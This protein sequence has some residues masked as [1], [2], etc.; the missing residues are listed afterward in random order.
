MTIIENYTKVQLSMTMGTRDGKYFDKGNVYPY[1]SV[2]VDLREGVIL[3]FI[4]NNEIIGDY[5]F[6]TPPNRIYV[7]QVIA[8]DQVMSSAYF[9]WIDMPQITI[10][11]LTGRCLGFN[12]HIVVPARTSI[13]YTGREQDGIQLGFVL[14]NDDGIYQD[15]KITKKITDVY[16]G[17][18]S[19]EQIP[20]F[21]QR[22]QRF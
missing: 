9:V 17:V 11:N 1:Q 18:I 12:G 8:K 6:T 14:K 5:V 7:G 10:H 20:A 4:N 2:A 15:F 16:Y 3:R 21:T 13:T 22:Y 19:D